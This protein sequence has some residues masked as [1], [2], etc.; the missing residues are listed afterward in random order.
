MSG[1]VVIQVKAIVDPLMLT[2]DQIQQVMQT[3]Q[4][5]MW[6]GLS[7]DAEKRKQTSLQMENTYVRSL[8]DGKGE[9]IY[10]N[11]LIVL[12]IIMNKAHTEVSHC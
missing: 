12:S 5:E 8:L 10:F 7:K 1:C 6:L 2:D 9:S 4:K 11:P 3:L